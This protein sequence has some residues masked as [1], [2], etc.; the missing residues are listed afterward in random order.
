MMFM[1][2][3]FAL[4]YYMYS[5]LCAFQFAW[6]DNIVE[7]INLEFESKTISIFIF[8][9]PK[10][11]QNEDFILS[12]ITQ[13]FPSV[14]LKMDRL[15][16]STDALNKHLKLHENPR[17]HSWFIVVLRND[18][19][20]KYFRK[21]KEVIKFINLN[22]SAPRPR[23]LAISTDEDSWNIQIFKNI[24]VYG[25]EKK[26]LDFTIMGKPKDGNLTIMYY[27][28]FFKKFYTEIS[29]STSKIFPDK[30]KD[31]NG[32]PLKVP[33]FQQPPYIILNF[34]N[35]SKLKSIK[36]LHYDCFKNICVKQNCTLHPKLIPS[37]IPFGKII[38][39]VFSNLEN[40][41]F[42]LL[43]WTIY[44]SKYDE[45]KKKMNLT[46]FFGLNFEHK[47]VIFLVPKFKNSEFSIPNLFW[48][49]LNFGIF[50][51]SFVLL[52]KVLKFSNKFW[53]FI[54]LYQILIGNKIELVPIS[55]LQ[56]ILYL[57]FTFST[58]GITAE[59]FTSTK[60]SIEERKT[61]DTFEDILKSNFP[62][63]TDSEFFM[64]LYK[65]KVYETKKLNLGI[66]WVMLPQK[67]SFSACI[68][69]MLHNQIVVCMTTNFAGDSYVKKHLDG[70]GK[71]TLKLLDADL[72]G[73]FA[74]FLYE[75]GSPFMENFED[76]LSRFVECG[77]IKYWENILRK[78]EFTDI[79]LI[80]RKIQD[81]H[82]LQRLVIILVLG[83][84]I[85]F[86]TFLFEILIS[87]YF[88]KK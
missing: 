53:N 15:S 26:Y 68:D 54:N 40:N 72:Y 2:Y 30:L 74:M 27:N 16:K 11:D 17:K 70:N 44:R 8:D 59:F 45:L 13:R 10:H 86:S 41:T 79:D 9:N 36:G 61:L 56:R 52:A 80:I 23:L 49:L 81:Q 73:D 60:I 12:K 83:Y 77:V 25:W 84:F 57:L 63:Y 32:F 28:P 62:V 78:S 58:I 7:K 46:A 14:L 66:D 19:E 75:N 35:S 65:T 29:N 4:S 51:S 33:V 64:N 67:L 47:K 55:F 88:K 38:N 34:T 39:Y 1:V 21:M 22:N 87:K 69:K 82:T 24:L 76:L 20:K 37:N 42:N 6:V 18:L 31:M 48:P 3:F 85:S 71:S 50:V 43:T 5:G